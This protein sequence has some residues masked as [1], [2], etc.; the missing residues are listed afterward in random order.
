MTLKLRFSSTQSLPVIQQSEASECGLACVAMLANYHGHRIDLQTLRKQHPISLKGANLLQLMNIAA[1]LGFIPRPLKLESAAIGELALPAILHWDM[2]HF[3]VLKSVSVSSIRI[4]CPARGILN[5]SRK[6]FDQHFTGVALELRPGDE[7][8]KKNERHP[9][10]LWSLIP[11]LTGMKGLV[12]QILLVSLIL[13]GLLLL[14]PFMIMIVTDTAL[15]SADSSMLTVIGIG[16]LIVAALTTIAEVFRSWLLLYFSKTLNFKMAARLFRHMIYLPHQFFALRHV[17]DVQSRFSSMDSV[18]ETITGSVLAALIDG[19]MIIITLALLFLYSPTLALI[20][21]GAT[22]LYALIRLGS[23]NALRRRSEAEIIDTAKRD[24]NFLET[25]RGNQSIKIMRGEQDREV[26]WQNRTADAINSEIRVNRLEIW[27]EGANTLLFGVLNVVVIWVGA[28]LIMQGE[29]TI[30]VLFAITSWKSNF[31]EKAASFIE[32]MIQIILLGLHRDR[33]ADIALTDKEDLGVVT[34]METKYLGQID[35]DGL[36]FSYSEMEAP[37]FQNLSFSI[38][39][40]ES[41]ALIGPSGCGKTTLMKVLIGLLKPT[42]GDVRIDGQPM[43]RVGLGRYRDVIGVVMQDDQLFSGSLRD[44]IT[45]FSPEPDEVQMRKAAV[46]AGIDEEIVAM[47]MGYN[48]LVGD[49][50]TVLSGGQKQR[51]LIARAL[52]R[53]PTILFL[54]EATSHLDDEL[55][56]KVSSNIGAMGI[57]RVM[58]AHRKETIASANRVIVL[59]GLQDEK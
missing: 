24:S 21:L 19:V 54:D 42:E 12:A 5:L 40:G 16:F 20:I 51:V 25:V 3:V 22:V 47:P 41:V 9:L 7:F 27:L 57:T 10:S 1:S 6:E 49:M 8:V 11:P 38:S 50:G 23:F 37:I 26:G 53:K 52:Y 58:I 46:M 30:G 15:A 4:H 43:S 59:S 31:E 33:I 39:P 56:K 48:T 32:A 17:G 45:F 35:V 34:E 13:Q 14:T 28:V 18:N 55:E 2:N 36:T 29:L 44:N